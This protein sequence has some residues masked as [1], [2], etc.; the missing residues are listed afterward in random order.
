MQVI[1]AFANP[2][3]NDMIYIEKKTF[4]TKRMFLRAVIYKTYIVAKTRQTLYYNVKEYLI[5]AAEGDY[6]PKRNQ[7]NCLCHLSH[8]VIGF[9]LFIMRVSHSSGQYSD[10]TH[11]E[12]LTLVFLLL[13]TDRHISSM[14]K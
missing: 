2:S 14:A 13:F 8:L 12:Y 3:Q 7:S 10:N 9:H 11:N 4:V 1:L 5:K 6:L